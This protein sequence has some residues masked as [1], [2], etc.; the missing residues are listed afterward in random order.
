MLIAYATAEGGLSSDVGAGAGPYATMLAEEIVQSGIEAVVMFR[1]VQRRVRAAIKQEPYLAFNAIGDVYFGGKPSAAI[2]EQFATTS[3]SNVTAREWRDVKDTTSVAVLERFAA[4]H[5]N[6]PVYATLAKNRIDDLRRT[7]QAAAEQEARERNPCGKVAGTW[8]MRWS[9]SH[10][11]DVV[12]RPDGYATRSDDPGRGR[13]KC[14]GLSLLIQWNDHTDRGAI[15]P[16][17]KLVSGQG[18]LPF[19]MTRN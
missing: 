2:S 14:E 16:D 4:A 8:A 12:L 6:D 13:W 10:S 9:A 18:A 5:K 19:F 1:A 3:A 15:S 7:Q 17:G 11:I